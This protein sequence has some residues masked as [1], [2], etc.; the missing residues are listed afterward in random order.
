[1]NGACA[2]S[3]TQLITMEEALLRHSMNIYQL[4]LRSCSLCQLRQAS[5]YNQ[6]D[7]HDMVGILSQHSAFLQPDHYGHIRE[8]MLTS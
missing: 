3:N 7:Q 5:H 1:M 2:D 6:R 8:C 4:L